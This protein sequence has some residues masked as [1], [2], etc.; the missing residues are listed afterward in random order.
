MW[1]DLGFSLAITAP[2]FSMLGF[3]ILFKRLGWITDEFAR[4]GSDLVFKV[5]LPCLLFVKLVETDF[6]HNLPIKL[7]FYAILATIAVFLILDR[8]IA[9]RLKKSFDRGAFVQGAFRSNMGIIGLAFCISAFGDR[10]VAAASIYLAVLTTLFNV[11][12]VI[13]LTRHQSISTNKTT[14]THIIASIGKNPLILSI[15]AGVLISLS[16]LQVP[17]FFLTTGGYFARMTLPLALLCAGASIRL[18]EF[19]ASKALYWSSAAKLVFVPL[20]ITL[21]GIAIGLR[22]EHL[23]V[24]YLM[25]ASP[26]AAA[27]YPMTQA[28]GGNHHLAAAIIAATS[29]GS[30]VFTTLGIFVLRSFQLI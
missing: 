18:Q 15:V 8:M 17:E 11:L 3:G 4:V 19:H 2:I 12:A 27:S 1:S 22:G 7:I 5:T 14:Y 9:V 20:I 6:V 10:V 25:C 29:L 21:G 28:M 24:L 13:T 23:G 30:M 26:T 16:G